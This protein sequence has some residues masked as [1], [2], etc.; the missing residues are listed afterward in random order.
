MLALQTVS[1]ENK[2]MQVQQ[3][4][5]PKI[6][7]LLDISNSLYQDLLG[8]KLEQTSLQQV[9]ESQWK[10]FALNKGLNPNSSGIYLPRNQTAVIQEENP[11][12]LFHEYFGHGLYCEQSLSGKKLVD[13]ERKLLEEEKQEFNGKQFTLEDVKRFRKNNLTFQ[14]LE[15]FRKQNLAK[16]EIFAIWTEYLL[17]EKFNLRD[18]FEEK[19]DSLLKPEKETIDSIINFSKQYGNLATFYAQGLARR[20]TPER[21][22][23]LLEDIYGDKL[24]RVK[25]ASLYGSRKEFSDIDVFIV[26]EDLEEIQ[27]DW[28]DVRVEGNIKFENRVRFLDGSLVCPL[29]DAEC[30]LGDR[31]YFET[32]KNQFKNSPITEEAIKHNSKMSKEQRRRAIEYPESS[33]ERIQGLAYSKS[34]LRNALALKQGKRK[35]TKE[36]ILCG[37]RE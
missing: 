18:M 14:E 6:R 37:V 20:T 12:S 34:Y 36:S 19:Y 3:K 15:E 21:V 11:L 35:L 26:G 2:M 17:F 25:F 10:E 27:T 9:S 32:M 5:A 23:K 22:R 4:Q 16:Y 1:E 7:N 28:I 31:E 8:Y 24:N 33:E 30:I 13:L 29:F